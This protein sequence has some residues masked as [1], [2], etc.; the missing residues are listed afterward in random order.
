MISTPYGA[1]A[2]EMTLSARGKGAFRP[3]LRMV[4]ATGSFRRR[5]SG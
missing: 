4:I 2:D 3:R 5:M 1:N